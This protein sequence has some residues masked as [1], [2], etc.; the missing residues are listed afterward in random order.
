ME[1]REK[2]LREVSDESVKPYALRVSSASCP[3]SDDSAEV[4]RAEV[5]SDESAERLVAFE[6]VDGDGEACSSVAK[7]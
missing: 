3:V 4:D 2:R 6:V 7:S 5:E 1:S